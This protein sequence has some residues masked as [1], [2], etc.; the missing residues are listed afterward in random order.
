MNPNPNEQ[1]TLRYIHDIIGNWTDPSLNTFHT[2]LDDSNIHITSADESL[3][4]DIYIESVETLTEYINDD[5]LINVSEINML[6]KLTFLIE[7]KFISDEVNDIYNNMI[8]S[9]Q[10]YNLMYINKF[11]D[12]YEFIMESMEPEKKKTLL[13]NEDGDYMLLVKPILER[14]YHYDL[15]IL[16]EN[17]E[18]Y[19]LISSIKTNMK[20][21]RHYEN[22]FLYTSNNIVSVSK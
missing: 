15:Y 5:K 18:L 11:N 6:D 1:H 19:K 17:D 13:K 16:I 21:V 22:T 3:I 20:N 2:S 12:L 10:K 8:C 9:F 7:N 14:E 4:T